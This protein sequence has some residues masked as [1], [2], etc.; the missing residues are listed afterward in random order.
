MTVRV[1]ICGI[2]EWE[3]ARVALD[4]GA[5]A[6]GFVFA[7]S[8]RYI[9]PEK[10]REIICRLPPFVTRVGVFVNEKRYAVQEIATFCRLDVLQFHGEESPEYCRG[11]SQQVI[12][13][14]SVKDRSVLE[15]MSRYQV[16]AYL[17]DAYVPGKRG[18]TGQTFDWEIAAEAR[19]LGRPI[20][21][22]GG[23]NPDNVGEAIARVKPYAVDV[24][25][26]V[27]TDGK[28]DARKIAEFMAAVR[29]AFESDRIT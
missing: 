26:G 23:L 17:L 11:Y 12:K 9:N 29:R 14:F 7:P 4:Q 8:R 21:L 28:K 25:S 22:A 19:K 3:E 10:A 16:D 5:H 20:I 6:L 13:A 2:T 27:E 1:K 24:S 18:G 15:D